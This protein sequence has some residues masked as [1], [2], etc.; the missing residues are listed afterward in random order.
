MDSIGWNPFN[1]DA[2]LVL[3]SSAVSFYKGVPVIRTNLDRSF[4]FLVIGLGRGETSKESIY[5]EFGHTFQQM[6][7]G[8]VSYGLYVVIPSYN[9]WGVDNNNY[10]WSYYHRPWEAMASI[11]GEDTD[12][13]YSPRDYVGVIG[14]TVSAMFF[15]PISFWFGQW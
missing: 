2:S 3:R 8:P 4:N 11:F 5:H 1:D 14:H 12:W 7:M 15:G 13:Y 10:S 6:L 9:E